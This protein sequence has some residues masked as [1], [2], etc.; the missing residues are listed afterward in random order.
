MNSLKII[1]GT[2]ALWLLQANFLLC[3][4]EVQPPS[5][6]SLIV[7]V[8]AGG[9]P[10]YEISFYQWSER[11]E[12][13]AKRSG[14]SVTTIGRHRGE[15]RIEGTD[16]DRLKSAIEQ[17]AEEQSGEL[18]IV[19]IG[20]GTFDRRV[21]RFNL[22]GPDV[23]A[24]ELKEWLRPLKRRVAVI[25]CASSSGPFIPILSSPDRIV[26]AATKSGTEINYSRFGDYMSQAIDDAAAD[27]DKDNQTSLW[28]A[29]LMASRRT[30]E[31]YDT[32]GRLATEHALLDDNGD[33][34]GVRADQFRGLAA[35]AKPADGKPLD[36]RKAH[37]WHLVP[38]PEESNIP[39]E[40]RAKRNE[41]ELAIEQ[42]R[43]RK[44]TFS[45]EDEYFGQLEHLLV[46]LAELNEKSDQ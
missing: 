11:W 5:R 18:W 20:H 1:T 26:I 23:S 7:V 30:A 16:Y 21:A 2:V 45:K 37:Q 27:L 33:G 24:D 36:G 44:A 39:P 12:A 34:Q 29:F 14:V 13:A 35:V 43:D 42:L 25:D 17:S 32:D 31:Y 6:Q 40:I 41:L 15:S 9:N 28:E 19:F 38:S 4:D 22:R 8:G 3:A 10:Q 46:D